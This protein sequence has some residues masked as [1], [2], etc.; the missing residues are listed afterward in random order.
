MPQFKGG[1]RVAEKLGYVLNRDKVAATPA[2]KRYYRRELELMTVHQL[3]EI[4][5]QERII[6]GIVNPLNK[7]LLVD[8]ILRYRGAESA[9]LIR[10][11]RSEDYEVL[12]EAVRHV[13]FQERKGIFLDCSAHITVYHGLSLDYY[14]DITIG[15]LEELNAT[16]AFLLDSERNLCAVFNVEAKGRDKSRLYLRKDATLPAME[17]D[18]KRYTLAFLERSVSEYFFKFYNGEISL[19]P[20]NIPA[21]LVPLLDF[22]VKEPEVLKMPA[23]IDFGTTNTVAGILNL[24]V[25]GQGA[26]FYSERVSYA[27]F[28]DSAHDFRETN[29]VPSVI[30]VLSL[31]DPTHPKYAFGFD[32]QNLAASR[33]IDDGYC[34]FYDIK[35]WIADYEKEEE[36]LDKHGRRVCVKR[37]DILREFFLYIIHSLENRI[38]YRVQNV[39]LSCPVKQKHKFQ[40]L[41]REILPEYNI[42]RRDMIDEGVS[43]L[44]NTISEMIEN[45]TVPK[46]Q[47]L[48]ALII[49]CGGGTMDIS[50]CA[51]KVEDRRVAY[52]IDIETG[53]ENGSTDFGGNNLTYRI[54]QMLK[55][56]LV[57]A[58]YRRS[59][60]RQ[61]QTI[62]EARESFYGQKP[63]FDERNRKLAAEI[64]PLQQL[65]QDFDRAIFRFVDE[66]GTAPLYKNFEQAYEQAEAIIPTRFKDWE[67]RTREE[68]FRVRNNF[69]F[70]FRCAE[71]IKKEF[72]ENAFALKVLLAVASNHE[73]DDGAWNLYR[74]R[75]LQYDDTVILPMDKWKITVENSQGLTDL[76][77]LPDISFSIFEMNLILAP[78]IYGIVQRFMDPLYESGELEDYSIIKLSGQSCKIDIFRTA[79]KEFVPGKVI[80]S[81]RATKQAKEPGKLAEISS[82][83]MSCID[84]VLKYLRDK[85]FGY[86]DVTI[87]NRTPHLPYILTGFTHNGKEVAMIHGGKGISHGV[88]SRNMDDL[89]L[90]L[91]LKDDQ[92]D[93]RHEFFY[94]CSP[95]EFTPKRQEEIEELYGENIP[96]DDTDNIVEREVKFFV[97]ADPSEWGFLVAPIYREEETL[98]M[99]REQFFSFEDDQW[100]KSFFD[101]TN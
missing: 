62:W 57:E 79:L 37:K 43:V 75:A 81:R 3:R 65:M 8:T 59:V 22:T 78:D 50:S 44:Y 23:A 38:K 91:Y 98:R 16:N 10:E 89:T 100:V 15:Y 83:K 4:A 13:I 76:N 84:G 30:G 14:D 11:Y 21:I 93:L 17:A 69:Y 46:N 19:L 61:E 40:R 71:Q 73:K 70:L 47:R 25:R 67:T 92:G 2:G 64:P 55:L 36:L 48:Q 31:E 7:E 96:Q 20:T 49:D 12:A 18:I 27:T 33:Y 72:F 90:T 82:L 35:R 45:R 60:E 94:Y 26:G 56:R 52:K 24:G 53:Y 77:D 101:G 6:S 99:G 86:A 41:F 88:L 54:L 42:E 87:T 32:A 63:S 1:R 28:Y 85:K 58:L 74:E 39:H 29:M 34:I 5:R 95:E 9:M 66:N 51:F 97:W 80:K 68:Y